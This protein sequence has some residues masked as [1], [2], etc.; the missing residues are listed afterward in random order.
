MSASTTPPSLLL[1]TCFQGWAR[2]L[3][4]GRTAAPLH[5]PACTP[6]RGVAHV[7]F[8]M[9]TCTNA[10][11]PPLPPRTD[12][13]VQV[14]ALCV[15]RDGKYIFT[16]G[17]RDG[18]VHMWQ[19]NARVLAAQVELSGTGMPAFFDLIEGQQLLR[20]TSHCSLT[21]LSS[22]FFVFYVHLSIYTCLGGEEGELM[23]ELRQ[24]FYYAQIRKQGLASMEVRQVTP[25][26]SLPTC[27][28]VSIH[29]CG[30]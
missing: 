18:C 23:E 2:A 9:H 19:I 29:V 24:Y 21:H 11:F 28:S 26:V 4:A 1:L 25:R 5:Q 20:V 10:H 30:V 13:R 15:S 16:A 3:A 6:K 12:A 17:G 7:P 8:S 27:L 22:P 14:S